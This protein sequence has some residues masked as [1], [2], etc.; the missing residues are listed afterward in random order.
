MM[1]FIYLFSVF[2]NLYNIFIILED[3]LDVDIDPQ[4][5]SRSSGGTLRGRSTG[6][7]LNMADAFTDIDVEM[8]PAMGQVRFF[9]SAA[10]PSTLKDV[11]HMNP[12]GSFNHSIVK[13]VA[14]ILRQLVRRYSPADGQGMLYIV[15]FLQSLFKFE[16]NR[17]YVLC[18]NN[19][20][21]LKG[22]FDV[23]IEDDEPIHWIT[24]STGETLTY[25]LIVSFSFFSFQY[26]GI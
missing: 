13:T 25:L 11:E 9:F 2:N 3:D 26:Y 24:N 21:D 19:I 15:Y 8:L 20:W 23:A 16:D 17:I 22:P 14:P 4:G 5:S 6:N 18:K 1:V 10:N 7:T 12:S